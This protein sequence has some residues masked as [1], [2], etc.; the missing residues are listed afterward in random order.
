MFVV[1]RDSL[2]ILGLE[3]CQRLNLIKRVETSNGLLS[4][5]S[6]HHNDIFGEIGWLYGEHY[7]KIDKNAVPIIH[8]PRRVPYALRNKLKSE[9]IA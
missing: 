4:D 8:P 3:T 7:I 6:M 9:L 5:I 2:P 1:A